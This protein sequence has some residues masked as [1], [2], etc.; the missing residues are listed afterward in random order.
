MGI[1][2]QSESLSSISS[3]TTFFAD[4]KY[5]MYMP[6]TLPT[7]LLFVQKGETWGAIDTK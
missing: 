3:S 7:E 6:K 5:L 4:P 2:D 1:I